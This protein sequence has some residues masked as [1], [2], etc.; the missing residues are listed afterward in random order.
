L[1]GRHLLEVLVVLKIGKQ[2][3]ISLLQ[4]LPQL[5]NGWLSQ[6]LM[7]I[8]KK[9]I[10]LFNHDL[11][12]TKNGVKSACFSSYIPVLFGLRLAPS[13]TRSIGKHK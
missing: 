1:L 11:L 5:F 8:R 3:F 10:S 12:L 7:L 2:L 6:F 9:L 4:K 13:Q